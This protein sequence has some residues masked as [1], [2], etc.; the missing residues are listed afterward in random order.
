MRVSPSGCSWPH[1]F[2]L[3]RIDFEFELGNSFYWTEC[4]HLVHTETVTKFW[5]R[6]I[7]IDVARLGPTRV[8]SSSAG[9]TT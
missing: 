7:Y 4:L 9:M 1:A 3:S 8:L 2:W 5:R 6:G